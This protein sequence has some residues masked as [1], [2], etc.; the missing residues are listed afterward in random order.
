MS[1]RQNKW[2]RPEDIEALGRLLDRDIQHHPQ[3]LSLRTVASYMDAD[4]RF[5]SWV[6]DHQPKVAAD[7]APYRVSR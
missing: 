3:V 4:E 2:L 7:A 1:G 5:A 6:E